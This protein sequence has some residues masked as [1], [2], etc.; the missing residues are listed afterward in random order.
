M[1]T[2]VSHKTMPS[3]SLLNQKKSQSLELQDPTMSLYPSRTLR[4]RVSF[5]MCLY[6]ANQTPIPNSR[7]VFFHPGEQPWILSASDDQT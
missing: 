7:T 6:L 3:F 4:L 5:T 2:K 1:I